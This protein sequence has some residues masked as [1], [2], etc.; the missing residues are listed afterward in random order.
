MNATGCSNIIF[1]IYSST[2]INDCFRL[3]FK[4]PTEKSRF[5]KICEVKKETLWE[6]RKVN[7]WEVKKVKR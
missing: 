2:I 4:K 7:R 6:A 1:F 5:M 3:V